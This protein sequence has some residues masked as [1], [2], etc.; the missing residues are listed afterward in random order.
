MIGGPVST[1]ASRRFLAIPVV[2]VVTLSVTGCRKTGSTDITLDLVAGWSEVMTTEETARIDFGTAPARGHL[3]RGWYYDEVN[4]KTG[5]TFVWSRGPRSEIDLHLGWRR[6]LTVEIT[7]WAFDYPGA[8]SQVVRFELNAQPIAG[9]FELPKGRTRLV[10]DMPADAQIVGRNRLVARYGR[11]EAPAAVVEGATDERELAVAWSDLVVVGSELAAATTDA[12]SLH[13]PAGSRTDFFI[14]AVV[15]TELRITRCESTT[16]TPS[17]LEVSVRR[18]GEAGEAISSVGCPEEGITVPFAAGAGLTRLRLTNRPAEPDDPPAGVRLHRPVIVAPRSRTIEAAPT[19][20]P[21]A[22]AIDPRPNVIIYLVDAL[23]SDRLGVYGC[24]RDLSP[25]LDA[26]AADGIVFT[27]VTAQ[28]SWTK[29]AVASI[30]TGFWPREHGVNGPDDRLPDDLPILPELLHGVGYETGAVIANAFVGRQFG[31]ARGFDHFE[32]IDH[33][34]GRSEVIHRRLECWFDDRGHPDAPFF[35]YIHTIDPHA[36]YAPP[37]EFRTRFADAVKNPEVGQVETVRGLVLGTVAPTVELGRDL[38]D[39]YDAE[40]AANDD[41][42]GSLLDLL[43][44]RGELD[45]TIVIFTSDHGE[46]FGEH[47]SWTH[48][49][50]LYNE[51]LSIPLVVRMPGGRGGGQ[52]VSTPVQ[53]IDLLPT[54]VGLCGVDLEVSLPG[55]CLL[56]PTGAAR[57]EDDRAMLAYLDYWDRT[58]AAMVFDGW[59]LIRPL[60]AEFGAGPELFHHE[61]D[62]PE[63]RDRAGELPVRLGW[64]NG[65]LSESLTFQRESV[66][67]EIDPEIREQLEAL[68]YM[69]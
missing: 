9:R 6:D 40:V 42:F 65:R 45:D 21:E 48:G 18:E 63:A 34:R 49:L 14:D 20:Q 39:L 13:L 60:S 44:S 38:R 19:P 43:A 47:D 51:V 41:S 35:L 4:R 30:F 1:G 56:T 68:G 5:E 32:F 55:S 15:G 52:R 10:V 28:S 58:G 53:H 27:D 29:A 12:E 26:M 7:L 36:P 24:E 25:R 54:I 66:Q 31:F 67:T 17:I 57:V 62:R 22:A 37:E 59:K 50:D 8:S 69:H 16:A 64:L 2:I 61:L 33:R 3:G 23:R 11:V 46:A